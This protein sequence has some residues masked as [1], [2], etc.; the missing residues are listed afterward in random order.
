MIDNRL[1][2]PQ[3]PILPVGTSAGGQKQQPSSKAPSVSFDQVLQEQLTGLKFSH[4][5]RQRL[6]SRNI[7]LGPAEMAKLNQAVTKAAS[8]GAK[9]SLI[10]FDNNLAFVVSIKNMTVI[11]AID[12]E[13]IKDNVFTNIDSAVII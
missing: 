6:I 11:T 1:L 12:G 13:N 3:Q 5:A 8:K 9:E 4:H 2:Y 7:Q 10:L